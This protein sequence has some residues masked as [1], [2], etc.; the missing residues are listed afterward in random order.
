MDDV[1]LFDEVFIIYALLHMYGSGPP[2]GS[3]LAFFRSICHTYVIVSL[4]KPGDGHGSVFSNRYRS[5][6]LMPDPVL[7]LILDNNLLTLIF[8]LEVNPGRSLLFFGGVCGGHSGRAFRP[9][10]IQRHLHPVAGT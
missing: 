10:H 8:G 9:Y 5:G 7:A 2:S 4:L 3:E 1:E 6:N